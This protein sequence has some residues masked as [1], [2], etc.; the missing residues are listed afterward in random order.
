MHTKKV[1]II[2]PFFN[3]EN[4]IDECVTALKNQTYKNIEIILIDDGSTDNSNA[5]VAKH[6]DSDD[7]IYLLKIANSGPGVARNYGLLRAS[8]T[9]VMF[10][11]SDD[12]FEST[13]VETMVN[14]MDSDDKVDIALCNCSVIRNDKSVRD[15]YNYLANSVNG[16]FELTQ[17]QKSKINIVLWNKIFKK[18]IIDYFYI[19]FPNMSS[20]EDESFVY[21]YLSVAKFVHYTDEK[22]YNHRYREGSLTEATWV[23]DDRIEHY[24]EFIRDFNNFLNGTGLK[25][26]NVQYFAKALTDV[27]YLLSKSTISEDRLNSYLSQIYDLAIDIDLGAIYDKNL[28]DA[29]CKY[30]NGNIGNYVFNVISKITD[31]DNYIPLIFAADSNY[32]DYFCVTLQSICENA[33]E[34]HQY[35][36]LLLDC[37]IDCE[38]YQL[39]RRQINKYD[40]FHF[41]AFPAHSFLTQHAEY[42]V[43]RD[44]FSAAIYARFII[45]YI[46]SGFKKAIYLDTDLIFKRDV[47]ELFFTDIGNNYIAAVTDSNMEM[48][49]RASVYWKEYCKIVLKM[50]EDTPYINS[51]VLLFN[52]EL[53]NRD[54]VSDRCVK[55]LAAGNEYKLP[56]Q[57]VINMMCSN[58]IHY[59]EQGWNCITPTYDKM[60][61][62]ILHKTIEDSL[63]VENLMLDYIRA[64]KSNEAVYH[65]ASGNKPWNNANVNAS[66][67]WWAYC[68]NT[69]H[70]DQVF[71]NFVVSSCC[72]GYPVASSTSVNQREKRRV[73]LFGIPVAKILSTK[74]YKKIYL[75]GVKILRIGYSKN[76]KTISFLGLKF[77]RTKIS[78]ETEN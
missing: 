6:Q 31:K 66:N 34:N 57:D 13:A 18:E 35:I 46:M 49:R 63:Y 69:E 33:S 24:F 74:N 64:F 42:F 37:G 53:W 77:S 22:I 15:D 41:Y 72:T 3:T 40:N 47:A 39:I 45:P 52:I 9:Y 71:K 12:Y 59:L 70:Y 16:K 17:H 54:K 56:D 28:H 11:D 7:R 43:E 62:K 19:L 4:Y 32:I 68:R 8:G 21:K 73:K 29:I 30:C 48:E 38:K 60:Y 78:Y 61:N 10:C 2:V 26:S 25:S 67:L 65:Y 58:R 36:V 5:I 51:G 44:H 50:H 1:S 75:F 23:K 27:E 20:H 55:R 76:Q 14:L